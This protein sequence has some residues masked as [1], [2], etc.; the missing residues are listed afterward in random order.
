MHRWK[1]LNIKRRATMK[2]DMHSGIILN[3][4]LHTLHNPVP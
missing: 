1:T 3:I 4:M 2:S